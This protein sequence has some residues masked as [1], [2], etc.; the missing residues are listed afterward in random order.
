[1]YKSVRIVLFFFS[2]MLFG[3]QLYAQCGVTITADKSQVCV[4]GIV[5]LKV[6]GCL[7]CLG[8]DWDVGNGFVPGKDTFSVL[9]GKS[10]S[11]SVTVRL[12]LLGGGTCTQVSK[13][14]FVG[15]NTPAP[16]LVASSKVQCFGKDSIDLKDITIGSATRDWFVDGK[17]YRKG[18]KTLRVRFSR[19]TGYKGV[20]LVV[21]DSN[22]CSG[23]KFIDSAVGVFDSV[24]VSYQADVVKGCVPKAV[25]FSY[26]IDSLGVRLDSLKWNF[27]RK[28]PAPYNGRAFPK[29]TYTQADSHRV[30]FTIVTKPGCRYSFPDSNLLNFGDPSSL[31]VSSGFKTLCVNGK[32]SIT[33]NGRTGYPM[34]WSWIPQASQIDSGGPLTRSFSFP[35]TGLYQLK[36]RQVHLGCVSERTI[37]NLVTVQGPKVSIGVK[38]P[39]YCSIPDTL[40]VTNLTAEPKGFTTTWKWTVTDEFAVTTTTSTQKELVW[41]PSKQSDFDVKLVAVSTN[42]CRDSMLAKRAVLSDSIYV[43]AQ[44][45]P[46]TVCPGQKVNIT[47]DESGIRARYG[48]T[49]KWQITDRKG[50]V[51][52]T[53]SGKSTNFSS[54]DTG[55][56]TVRMI[57]FDGKSC[58]DTLLLKDTIKVYYPKTTLSIADSVVCRNTLAVFYSRQ[59]NGSPT[60]RQWWEVYNLDSGGLRI[61]SGRDSVKMQMTL[62]GRHKLQYVYSDT[63][64]GGCAFKL[65][66]PGLLYVNGP[67]LSITADPYE[68][69]APLKTWLKGKVLADPDFESK[70]AVPKHSWSG[71]LQ[72]QSVIDSPFLLTTRATVF[73]G[74]Q[75]FNL[76]Y[77]GR[78]GCLDSSI[79]ITTYGGISSGF[80]VGGTTRCPRD[81]YP[82]INNSSKIATHF[83]WIGASQGVKFIPTDTSRTPRLVFPKAGLYQLALIVFKGNDCSDTFNYPIEMDSVKANF[84]TKDTVA[85]CAP[86]MVELNNTSWR[87]V[88]SFWTF[89]NDP[90]IT[91]S[92]N[93]KT[94]QKVFNLNNP[95]GIDVKLVAQSKYGCR[96]SMTR[97]RYI[98]VVGPVADLR[99]QN[100]KGCEP[101]KVYFNNNSSFY[102]RYYLDYGDGIVRDSSGSGSHTYLVGNKALPYQAYYPSIALYDS[103]G[104]FVYARCPDS[105]VVISGSEASFTVDKTQ[106]CL[107][108]LSRFT[109]RSQFWKN[110]YW[111]FEADGVVDQTSTDPQWQYGPGFWRPRLIAENENGCRDTYQLPKPIR[112][113]AGPAVNI[114]ASD[115]TVCFASPI[116]FSAQVQGSSGIRSYQWDFGDETSLTDFSNKSIGQWAYQTAYQKLVSLSVTDSNNCAASAVKSVYIR[117]TIPPVNPGMSFISVL[118]DNRSV[119]LYWYSYRDRDFYRYHLNQDSAGYYLLSSLKNKLDTS[120][121][122]VRGDSLSAQ[123]VCYAV[124]VE[125]SCK[126]KGSYGVSHCTIRAS[127]GRPNGKPYALE[128][129][130]TPYKGWLDLQYYEIY[131]AKNGGPFLL[132]RQTKPWELSMLDTLLCDEPFCYY[133]VGVSKSGLRSR[134]NSTCG[135]PWYYVPFSV[136]P[137]QLATVEQSNYVALEW[138][139]GPEYYS[140]LTYLIARQQGSNWTPIGSTKQNI[141]YDYAAP[142]NRESVRYSLGYKDHCGAVS[143]WGPFAATIFAG[144]FMQNDAAQITWTPYEQWPEGIREYQVQRKDVNGEFQSLLSVPPTVLN[145][146]DKQ[147]L[148]VNNDTLRYRVIAIR[149]SGRADTSISNHVKLV[150]NARMYVPNAFTPNGD[151]RNDLFYAISMYIVKERLN[152]AKQFQMRIYSRWGELLFEGTKPDDAW[153][154]TYQGKACPDGLYVFQIR[155]IGYDGKLFVFQDNLTLMR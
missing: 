82:V 90:S 39:S 118:P 1:M 37:P 109:S 133:V 23:S 59:V 47:P 94:A 4:P 129:K 97:T 123:S 103:L 91:I 85:Y 67:V 120:Y 33:A 13:N 48:Y 31:T 68:D 54:K 26:K 27:G 126:I 84:F 35:D 145:W 83:K 88:R 137:M 75:F 79:Y 121:I 18:P 80:V 147:A 49:Y 113:F 106:I 104:C 9:V 81:T 65:W 64:N 44:I 15:V 8:Y 20:F 151:G 51:L 130:W 86:K 43:P 61:S 16:K 11:Y 102:S 99:M 3:N 111:D 128:L 132:H 53:S 143:A 28:G 25:Q 50:K 42:G 114:K 46:S 63:S 154:G 12:R 110:L 117:D 77:R 100:T 14:L 108:E 115:D 70:K 136:V 30:T 40:E 107:P 131:R 71:Y 93:N 98:K 66:Y 7:T 155:G 116:Y 146:K 150:P 153:D 6:S 76:R 96:D 58:Y 112:V 5:K 92:L 2:G 119:G 36:L 29:V 148:S 149:A 122:L 74:K 57:V 152:P 134:S 45:T 125:D 73:K 135:K 142:V 72:G 62:N 19:P 127:V 95:K 141:F 89:G 52:G 22:G 56:F 60:S 10:G 78:S 32:T 69:C 17:T 101:L 138:D 38:T 24:K 41:Y 105:V 34:E 139:H 55:K 140:G 144:G 21:T 124:Q 87:A